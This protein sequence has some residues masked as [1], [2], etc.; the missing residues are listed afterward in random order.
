MA[1]GW[2]SRPDPPQSHEEEVIL[3]L[4]PVLLLHVALAQVLV[5]HHE[6]E[7]GA[8]EDESKHNLASTL[9][10]CPYLSHCWIHSRHI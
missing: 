10:H 1:S 2:G 8:A 7:A 6:L 4:R 3:R 9:C 5:L